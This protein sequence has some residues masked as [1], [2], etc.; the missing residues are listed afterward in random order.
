MTTHLRRPAFSFVASLASPRWRTYQGLIM[1]RSNSNYFLIIVV[2]PQNLPVFELN[3]TNR[4]VIF[5]ISPFESAF[6]PT[7]MKDIRIWI[8]SIVIIIP[9]CPNERMYY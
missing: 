7:V 9:E 1:A 5:Q 3:N 4:P 6:G 8:H 2:C